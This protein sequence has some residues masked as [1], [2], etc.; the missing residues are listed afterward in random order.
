M[1]GKIT[2]NEVKRRLNLD[3]KDISEG[4]N[5]STIV[6]P[7]GDIRMAWQLI[8]QLSNALEK[9]INLRGAA[10]NS[11]NMREIAEQALEGKI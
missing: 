3:R 10:D 11:D 9:I 6:Y 4:H 2:I 5:S 1:T 7:L 8:L